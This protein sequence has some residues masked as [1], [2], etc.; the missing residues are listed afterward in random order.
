LLSKPF[1]ITSG[2]ALADCRLLPRLLML[3]L[4]LLLMLLML[5]LLPLAAATAVFRFFLPTVHLCTRRRVE[6]GIRPEV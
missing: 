6:A 4:L 5:L 3:L 2:V 1:F